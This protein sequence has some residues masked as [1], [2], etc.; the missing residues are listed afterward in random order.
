MPI[1]LASTPGSSAVTIMAS[2]VSVTSSV[3]AHARRPRSRT[4]RTR[5]RRSGRR[6]APS[7]AVARPPTEPAFA[8]ASS[9]L[10][11]HSSDPPDPRTGAYGLPH[12][13]DVDSR[14][15][16]RG[17]SVDGAPAPHPVG[18][19]RITR[20]LERGKSPE[21]RAPALGTSH[22]PFESQEFFTTRRGREGHMKRLALTQHTM[23]CPLYD[24]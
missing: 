17:R 2:F 5:V 22:A 8:S 6:S 20:R 9:F 21:S 15:C 14:G 4:V 7:L 13:N 19:R 1:S 10:G 24:C 12:D 11:L 3:G 18:Q 16:E 23:R